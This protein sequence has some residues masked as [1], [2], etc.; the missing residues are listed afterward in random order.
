MIHQ[1]KVRS[2]LLMLFFIAPIS[3]IAQSDSSSDSLRNHLLVAART[4]MNDAGVCTLITLDN[5]MP[6]A[7]TMEAFP[8]EDDFIV[9]FGTNSKS[10]KVEQ[11][12]E[13]PTAVLHYLDKDASGYVM[14]HGRAELVNDQKLKKEWWKPSWGAFYPDK[15]N[16][17]LIKFIPDSM[18]VISTKLGILGD[19]LTWKPMTV[20]F[21]RD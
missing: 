2:V 6:A 15:E 19:S 21:S 14:I 11:I 10:R 9:W 20:S 4:I 13:N 3:G 1:K 12:K 17:L 7:R 8:P 5:G 16:F 18:E